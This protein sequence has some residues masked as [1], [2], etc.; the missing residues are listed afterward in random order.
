L[1]LDGYARFI[2]RY[3]KAVIVVWIVLIL[4][5][6]PLFSLVS[7]S[8]QQTL[9]SAS[10]ESAVAQNIIDADFGNTTSSNVVFLVVSSADATSPRVH[11]FVDSFTKTAMSD[12][13]LSNLTHV[14]S[15]YDSVSEL[16]TG[17][18][19]ADRSLRNE[20]VLVSSSFFGVPSTFVRVWNQSTS[21]AFDPTKI[22]AATNETSLLLAS[23]INNRTQLRS[24]VQ[25]LEAFAYALGGTYRASPSMP[26]DAR[27]D[28][29]VR[30]V[31]AALVN[32]SYP[33]GA[34]RS[35][36]TQVV[37]SFTVWNYT[38]QQAIET[39][40]VN[41]V[42]ADTLYSP[43]FASSAYPLSLASPSAND[44]S[45][46]NSIV[47]SPSGSGIPA[48]YK[49]AVASFV[50]PDQK[51]MLVVLSFKGV[52]ESDIT[53]VRSIV[54][55]LAPSYGLD[56]AVSVTG[57]VA[58]NHDFRQASL[59]DLTLILPLTI[60]ILIAATGIFFRSV[61]APGASLAAIGIALGIADSAILYIVGTY[62]VGIDPYI[63]S[64]LLAVIIGVGTDYS[65]FLLARYREE[66][67]RGNDKIQAVTKS[68]TWAGESIATSG[69]TVI[70]SF[71]FLGLF[72]TVP[73][74]KGIGYVVGGGVL[75]A[76]LGSLTLVPSIAML[77][78]NFVFW[79]NVGARFAK[80]AERVE[81]SIQGKTGYFSR[82]ARFS[83][84]HAKLVVAI[85]LVVTVPAAYTWATAP[86]GYDFLAAAPK[87][88]Q[89][90]EAFNNL[91]QSFG[92]GAL[93]P[94]YAV[95]KF[96]SPVWDNSSY[97]VKEMQI[98][99]SLSNL[100][101]A[102][103]NVKGVTGPTRPGGQWVDYYTLGTDSRSKLLEKMINTMISR[104]GT[105][106]LVR[107]DLTASPESA[108]SLAT[109]QQLRTEY[110]SL[111]KNDSS[112]LRAVYLGGAAGSTLDSKNIVNA[113]FGQIITYVMVGVAIVLLIV[114]GSLFL[115]LF[116]IVSVV[117]SIAWTLAATDLVFQHFYSF[118]LLFITP[119]ALFVLLL[120]LGMD[121][122]IFILTRIREEAT[123]GAS[124]NEA[125]T[126]AV[127][128]TG[129]IITAAAL[130]LAG[131]LATLMISNNLLLKEFGFAF[132]CS[133][134][135]D[136]MI[137]RTY[138]VPSVMSLVGKWNFYA[139]GRLQRVRTKDASPQ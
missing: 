64:I 128:R 111:V 41:Q 108:T 134:L 45:L 89:S 1:L 78:P 126:A 6:V 103:S 5:C 76:L 48:V 23:S 10:G 21:G 18:A 66:R 29:A 62:L 38:S 117:M 16:V 110:Q 92:A 77:V 36:A 37:D 104:N 74:L 19:A 12:P 46:V 42:A 133:I 80:Y 91:T 30:S 137:V 52:T 99:D 124:L 82:S 32:S 63:L 51:T 90:V 39:F 31:A 28:S 8:S 71:I 83:I 68:I 53:A 27:V 14:T 135:I 125:I 67:A 43:T 75:V 69:F 25:Y 70:I 33:A 100:T 113:Q 131:S 60:I 79:P 106:V 122:N 65:V 139:P 24:S 61:V 105:Y 123:K 102:T 101:L 114:L 84:K 15:A 2:T 49:D 136:A 112:Q 118:P 109:A 17:A 132:C 3:H 47:A 13:S 130:I 4:A 98:V 119:L 34:G 56:P 107:I 26:L 127:E 58:L 72:S 9:G 96:S 50:S 88:L 7:T 94:T 129:G 85:A 20:T 81:K 121:Y 73:F 55:A 116:A 87:N 138:V 35:F 86:V 120:G 44:T 11:E 54:S 93:Y 22:G 95:M 97:N 59:E 57:T 115:P 40:V